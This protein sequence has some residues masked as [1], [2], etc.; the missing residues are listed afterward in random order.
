M[1]LVK[2]FKREGFVK[3]VF[4]SDC[5]NHHQ[6]PFSEKMYELMCENY[7]FIA[8]KEL[9]KERKNL[10]WREP[11]VPD[12]VIFSHCSDSDMQNAVE[13]LS[14]ADVIVTG[15]AP[16]K[17]LWEARRNNKLILRYAERPFKKRMSLLKYVPRYI[18]WH[19]RNPKEKPIYML[20]SSAFTSADYHKYN[21]F[22]NKVYKWG[23]FPEKR[24][25]DINDLMKKKKKNS[26]LWC[27]RFISWKHPELVIKL[28]RKLKDCYEDFQLNI[29]GTGNMEQKL[30][31]LITVYKLEKH[32]RLLGAMS[33]DEVRKYMEQTEIYVFTSDFQEGWGAVLNEAMNSACAV[34]ASHAIGSVPYLMENG[35]NGMVY[36]NQDEED[37]FSKVSYLLDHKTERENIGRQAYNTIVQLWNS[38]IAA[39][40]LIKLIEE[41][42][43]CGSCDLYEDG[44]CSKAELIPN[45][46]I[47]YEM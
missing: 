14:M 44:P 8:T 38:D 12:Y 2:R 17:M 36:R 15:S 33:P 1:I 4:L 22:E 41:L 18:R 24:E 43:A 5:F 7:K 9:G 16:E 28:A 37:L 42:K 11:E 31:H 10:G 47:E 19:F 3:V 20:C 45:D 25:Y 46:W 6:K 39:E 13:Q 40:R 23:Y 32:V 26:I 34:V 21:L 27:G 30:K 35:K 29:I